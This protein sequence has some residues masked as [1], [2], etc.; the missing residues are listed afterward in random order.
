M[1][2]ISFYFSHYLFYGDYQ[3][4]I[5]LV[6][7]VMTQMKTNSYKMA[8]LEFNVRDDDGNGYLRNMLQCSAF[9][10]KMMFMIFFVTNSLES[11]Y[12]PA[13]KVALSSLKY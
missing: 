12:K 13:G 11:K 3:N 9:N 6:L 10:G 4:V 8:R 5:V 1:D 7:I 2:R